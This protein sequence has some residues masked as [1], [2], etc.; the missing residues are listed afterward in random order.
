MEPLAC[1]LLLAA[2]LSVYA[3]GTWIGAT[4]GVEASNDFA[5]ELAMQPSAVLAAAPN[6]EWWR[7]GSCLLL[8]TW[9]ARGARAGGRAGRH[10]VARRGPVRLVACWLSCSGQ[11]LRL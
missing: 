11:K 7:L 9:A 2:Q 3:L 6:S 10:A 4:Q 1:Y 5:L 8:H